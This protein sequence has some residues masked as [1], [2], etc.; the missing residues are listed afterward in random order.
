LGGLGGGGA[1][2]W[3]GCGSGCLVGCAMQAAGMVS[4]RWGT[5]CCMV[6][7]AR[8]RGT[9]TKAMQVRCTPCL[10]PSHASPATYL[11]A[12]IIAALHHCCPQAALSEA[13]SRAAEL[14]RRHQQLASRREAMRGRMKALQDQVQV[15][16]QLASLEPCQPVWSHWQAPLGQHSQPTGVLLRHPLLAGEHA[17]RLGRCSRGKHQGPAAPAGPKVT[18]SACLGVTCRGADLVWS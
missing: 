1:D 12:L 7:N 17:S 18:C 14:A 11:I 4:R 3:D 5:V 2:A 9:Q 10:P 13:S 16:L 15:R 8:T 6:K